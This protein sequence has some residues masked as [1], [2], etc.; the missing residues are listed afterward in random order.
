MRFATD[1]AR[2]LHRPTLYVQAV[3]TARTVPSP[4]GEG[5]R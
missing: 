2:A 5:Q 3:T 1:T 4:R